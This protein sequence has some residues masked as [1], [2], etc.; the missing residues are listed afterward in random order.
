MII[1]FPNHPLNKKEVDIDYQ[2]ELE[3][4]KHAG[5][6]YDFVDYDDIVANRK[7]EIHRENEL[8]IYRGWMLTIKQYN[9]LYT[10]LSINNS[11]E[12][13][14]DPMQYMTL[15][16]FPYVY[17]E[18][19][20]ATP[21]IYY[22]RSDKISQKDL[23]ML[24]NTFSIHKKVLVKDWVKSTKHDKS[25]TVINDV[26]NEK[27]VYAV[28]KKLREDR[29]DLFNKGFVFKEFIDLEKDK[30]SNPKEY[31]VFVLNG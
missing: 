7:I 10:Q 17:D 2:H 1:L 14:N 31:R 23:D 28:T 13:I 5:F 11:I 8:A 22:T 4:V 6:E 27:E 12:L 20:Q 15:H 26:T 29:G 19:K 18:I 9:H 24:Y 21:K 30:H 3:A 25:A 16:Y